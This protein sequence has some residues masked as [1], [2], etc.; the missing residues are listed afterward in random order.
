MI[1]Q[2]K[3]LRKFNS[4]LDWK[5]LEQFQ[6]QIREMQTKIFRFLNE[7]LRLPQLSI[8][9]LKDDSINILEELKKNEFIEMK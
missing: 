1:K 2:Q 9:G 7:S 3:D 5:N 8:D 4:N 6:T